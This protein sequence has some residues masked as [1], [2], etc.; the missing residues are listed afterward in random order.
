MTAKP[1]LPAAIR[2]LPLADKL[3]RLAN[4]DPNKVEGI[5]VLVDELLEQAWRENFYAGSRGGMMLKA[6]KAGPDLNRAFTRSRPR[7]IYGTSSN[8]PCSPAR[9]SSSARTKLPSEP[10]P[11]RG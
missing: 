10:K 2:R 8:L 3:H 11:L 6:A 4:L 1:V 7:Q 9:T 5:A